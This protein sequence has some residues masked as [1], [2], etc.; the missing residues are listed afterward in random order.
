MDEQGILL[1]F[2]NGLIGFPELTRLRL[3]E[4]ADAYPLKFLQS[5]DQPEVSFVVIDVA[6]LKPDYQVPMSSE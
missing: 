6:G 5:E 3:L 1:D 2:P 4:P